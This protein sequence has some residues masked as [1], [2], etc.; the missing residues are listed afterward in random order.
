MSEEIYYDQNPYYN[1]GEGGNPES[2][3]K[4]FAIAALVL[5]IISIL[6]GCCGF[7]FITA[8]LSIIFGIIALVKRQGGTVMSIVGITL[9][10]VFTVAI[11]ALTIFINTKFGY[12]FNDYMK[13]VENAPEVVEEYHETGELPDY[14]EKYNDP[15]YDEFWESGG[16]DDFND[17]FD[18]FVEQLEEDG[19]LDELEA[20]DNETVFD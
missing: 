9:S 12:I 20:Y 10:T 14:L 3:K 15:K 13:F 16:F 7:G 11:I 18:Q 8:P 4:G 1:N 19:T 6:C 2:E 17:F 5:G